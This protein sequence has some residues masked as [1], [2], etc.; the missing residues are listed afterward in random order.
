MQTLKD[1]LVQEIEPI[2]YY[3]MIFPNWRHGNNV[4]CP[5]HEDTKPSLSFSSDGKTNCHAASCEHR[6]TNI[7]SFHM[8]LK[9]LSMKRALRQLYS[10]FIEKPVPA[11]RYLENHRKLVKNDE[12]LIYLLSRR[13]WQRS[14]IE[15]HKIGIDDRSSRIT[16][17]IFNRFGILENVRHYDVFKKYDTKMHGIAGKNPPRL[18]PEA[19]LNR[20]IIYLFSG[21]P[22]L[23][24]AEK[25]AI[26]GVTIT[27][28]EHIWTDEFTEMMYKKHV[29]LI[30]DKDKA[31]R[32]STKKRV[33][34]IKKV[35]QSLKVIDLPVEE[36]KDFTDYVV[37][38]GY[39]RKEFLNLIQ[40]TEYLIEKKNNVEIEENKK[41]MQQIPLSEA[42]K[43]K[44]YLKN[45]ELSALIVGKHTQPYLPPAKIQIECKGQESDHPCDLC[46]LHAEND[47]IIDIPIHHREIVKMVECT[48]EARTLAIKRLFS[49]P[50]KCD[51]K[52]KTL[53]TF[54]IIK[55]K[56]IPRSDEGIYHHKR[57]DEF[58]K[59]N[60]YIVGHD[61]PCNTP[62]KLEGFTAPDKDQSATHIITKVTPESD[63]NQKH[64]LTPAHIKHFK[65]FQEGTTKEFLHKR[66]EMFSDKIT[67]IYGKPDLHLEVDLVY[68]SVLSFIFNTHPVHRG[69]LDILILGD[70]QL[71][72]GTVF[73]RMMEFYKLGSVISAENATIVGILGGLT[74]IGEQFVET[75]GALPNNT[76]GLM[77]IDELANLSP[78]D[79]GRLSRV[80][81]EGVAEINKGDVHS[82][83][84]CTTRLICISNC[85]GKTKNLG[86]YNYGTN[87]VSELY[88]HQEDIS[89]CDFIV[90]AAR[91]EVSAKVINKVRHKNNTNKSDSMDSGPFRDLIMWIWGLEPSQVEFSKKATI[92]CLEQSIQLGN[93]YEHPE[94]PL[95]QV[96][97]IRYKIARIA[98]AI[99]GMRF[100]SPDG[101]RLL[102]KTK[103][104]KF[105][106]GWL[107]YLYT[108][109]SMGYYQYAQSHQVISKLK[110]QEKLYEELNESGNIINNCE[111]LLQID[112]LTVDDLSSCCQLEERIS[113]QILANKLIHQRAF[114]RKRGY[115]KKTSQ[116]V[117][118]LRK[119][120]KGEIEFKKS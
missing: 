18:W 79:I 46:Q 99:A 39:G 94:F 4:M 52:I 96:E 7:I 10:I 63:I 59:R 62:V 83:A 93:T 74:K 85:R 57:D 80:R 67:N 103:H 13:G 119:V 50:R 16:I 29:I 55:A 31:G 75:W 97:N 42:S 23:I 12:T 95:V 113:G 20:K 25:L 47:Y 61:L 108:K 33:K 49:L 91:N 78:D 88:G 114:I 2:D 22:A 60:L 101:K 117:N 30:P 51:I 3:K 107:N 41:E 1:Y 35:V 53:E 32:M 40:N 15:R 118:F 92:Y 105:A 77:C 9:Q 81:S 110:N 76:K 89:R 112:E 82:R 100:S 115:Y 58:V 64:I 68:H 66:Y 109:P 37:N 45:I 44:H 19:R 70:T 26:F 14:S 72:K 28:G 43:S 73:Q 11:K 17:P 34:S 8:Q 27:G 6:S 65:K 48:D 21:E 69:W 120:V 38:G 36:G 84:N 56:A 86:D 90:T 104:I 116:F 98:I 24:C 111:N 71:G 106:V 54:N 5:F 87:A 102:V